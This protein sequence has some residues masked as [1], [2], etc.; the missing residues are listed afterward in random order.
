MLQPLVAD[1]PAMKQRTPLNARAELPNLCDGRDGVGLLGHH[2]L[3]EIEGKIDRVE[4]EGTDP[5]GISLQAMIDLPLH[6]SS[7]RLIDEEAE[8][9]QQ[10]NQNDQRSEDPGRKFPQPHTSLYF[11]ILEESEA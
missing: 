9:D 7:K 10:N 3:A 11:S 5:N 6:I 8:R 2:D 1:D 4:I